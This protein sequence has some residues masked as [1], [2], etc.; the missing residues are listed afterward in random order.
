MRSG[1][2]EGNK[3]RKREAPTWPC[4]QR[5]KVRRRTRFLSKSCV[6]LF[7]PPPPSQCYSINMSAYMPV[8]VSRLLGPDPWLTVV[9]SSV[10]CKDWERTVPVFWCLTASHSHSVSHTSIH[11]SRKCFFVIYLLGLKPQTV[12]GLLSALLFASFPSC[13]S[14]TE[15]YLFSFIKAFYPWERKTAVSASE[16]VCVCVHACVS[17]GMWSNA[18]GYYD[19]TEMR[20]EI[21]LIGNKTPSYL[22]K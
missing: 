15:K 3:E 10:A 7:F 9:F 6:V 2:S 12:R 14:Y 13:Y 5:N 4:S 21:P 19:E 8:A 17:G 20:Q 1:G 22:F 16:C 11:T 18:G